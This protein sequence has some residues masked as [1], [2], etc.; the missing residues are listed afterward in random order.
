MLKVGE[1]IVKKY[2]KVKALDHTEFWVSEKRAERE[3]SKYIE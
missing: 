3:I 2:S 1:K